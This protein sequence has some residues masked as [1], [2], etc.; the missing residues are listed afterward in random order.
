MPETRLLHAVRN[1]E[2][3]GNVFISVENDFGPLVT[4][5]NA[6]A[7]C[8]VRIVLNNKEE[9]ECQIIEAAGARVDVRLFLGDEDAPK[10][11]VKTVEFMD[12]EELVIY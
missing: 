12:I 10:G 2:T 8:N 1:N 9:L 4:I 5:F 6:F 3:G 11:I 7:G